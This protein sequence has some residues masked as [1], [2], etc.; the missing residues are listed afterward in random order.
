M[1]LGAAI[2]P[3]FSGVLSDKIGRKPVIIIADILFIMTSLALWV[4]SDLSLIYY[5]RFLAGIALGMHLMVGPV[6]LSEIAPM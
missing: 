5:V 1:V 4:I 6:Y 3:L 2:S